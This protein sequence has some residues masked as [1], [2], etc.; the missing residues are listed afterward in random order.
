M[1][2]VLIT[3]GA[4]FI[5]FNL[6]K[7]F[8]EKYPD[9]RIIHLDRMSTPGC[10]A[11]VNYCKTLPQFYFEHGDASILQRVV[12]LF[13][14][15]D[16]R[17]VVVLAGE[18]HSEQ[19]M[20]NPRPLVD[21]NIVALFTVLETARQHWQSEPHHYKLGYENCRLHL[22]STTQVYGERPL[23]T[24]LSEDIALLPKTP[25]AATR[26]GA[27]MLALSYLRTY[28]LNVTISRLSSVYGGGQLENRFLPM[29]MRRAL[30][31]KYLVLG[32][33]GQKKHDWLYIDDAIQAL[34]ILIHRGE[35]GGIYN[36][37]SGSIHTDMEIMR[38][39]CDILDVKN[40]RE[41]GYKYEE[42]IRCTGDSS[43]ADYQ[44]EVDTHKIRS[45]FGW[46]PTEQFET[47]LV[48]TISSL[49]ESIPD[50]RRKRAALAA[51]AEAAA[52]EAE[53][54]QEGIEEGPSEADL[55]AQAEKE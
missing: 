51:A 6:T 7:Y 22:V 50:K 29:M 30:R 39:M 24:V 13:Q 34:D 32:A 4:G 49:L 45:E 17:D 23:G 44:V 46:K 12:S 47:G 43:A 14:E 20:Q 42:L 53:N 26:V 5:G 31:E 27:E 55:L 19:T 18:S 16:V 10:A 35:N 8:A 48:R 9:Y 38:T 28:G 33:N 41:G 2:S 52:A 37:A 1:R 40:P 11:N 25:Y 3:G 21:S 36:V 15:F 54:A